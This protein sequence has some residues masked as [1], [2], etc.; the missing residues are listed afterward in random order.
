MI[1]NLFIGRPNKEGEHEGLDFQIFETP[2]AISDDADDIISE[3]YRKLRD[4]I[5]SQRLVDKDQLDKLFA[6]TKDANQVD[7]EAFDRMIS[8]L[9]EELGYEDS[10]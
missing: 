5:V 7:P 6:D 10:Q 2:I 9:K 8:E 3:L 1:Q 4:G